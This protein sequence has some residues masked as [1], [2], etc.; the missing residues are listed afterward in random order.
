MADLEKRASSVKEEVAHAYAS[1][2]EAEA[3]MLYE[4]RIKNQGFLLRRATLSA[5]GAPAVGRAGG[6]GRKPTRFGREAYACTHCKASRAAACAC[7]GSER[8]GGSSQLG[9]G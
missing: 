3:D 9:R 4:Q 8:P 1:L 7:K 5:R 6:H 2:D